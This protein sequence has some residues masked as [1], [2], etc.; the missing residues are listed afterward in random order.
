[1]FQGKVAGPQLFM[2]GKLKVT[3][4]MGLAMKLGAVLAG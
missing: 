2:M 3:G 1:L 4:N